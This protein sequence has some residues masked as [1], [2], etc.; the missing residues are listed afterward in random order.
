MSQQVP[1]YVIPVLGRRRVTLASHRIGRN[2][3]GEKNLSLSSLGCDWSLDAI[4]DAHRLVSRPFHFNDTTP[5]PASSV[6]VFSPSRPLGSP[7]GMIREVRPTPSEAVR[8]LPTPLLRARFRRVYLLP[9]HAP[10]RQFLLSVPRGGTAMH[11]TDCSVEQDSSYT[12]QLAHPQYRST[13]Q[14]RCRS[15]NRPIMHAM[16]PLADW[17]RLAG[18]RTGLPPVRRR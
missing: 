11:H 14:G 5:S 13:Q 9:R 1:T 17:D 10:S 12:V 4:R 3:P 15:S 2:L 16:S 18:L 7:P 6:R 8:F